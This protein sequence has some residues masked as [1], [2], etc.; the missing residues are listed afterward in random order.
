M[1]IGEARRAA[2]STLFEERA[3]A[4]RVLAASDADAAIVRQL[5]DD[6]DLAVIEATAEALIERRDTLGFAALLAGL[7]NAD[8]QVANTLLW[9]LWPAQHKYGLP[10][11][12][13]VANLL[14]DE[15]SAVRAGAAIA[16]EW[17]SPT[18]STSANSDSN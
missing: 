1:D 14:T 4:G 13:I 18:R 7:A 17:H 2:N 15:D 5:L 12:G 3:A 11:P 10:V 9:I 16:L 8:D 6:Q